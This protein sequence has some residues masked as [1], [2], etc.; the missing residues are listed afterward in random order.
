M[1]ADV[2]AA[3]LGEL[4]CS[5]CDVLTLF[6][7]T[8]S[9]LIEFGDDAACGLDLLQIQPMMHRISSKCSNETAVDQGEL[10]E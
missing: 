8:Q 7:S 6:A 2:E 5:M 9:A 3:F 1:E 10:R 4:A